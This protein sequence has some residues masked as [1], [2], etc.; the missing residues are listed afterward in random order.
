MSNERQLR[1]T[2]LQ[3]CTCAYWESTGEAHGLALYCP[4]TGHVQCAECGATLQ[5]QQPPQGNMVCSN[6]LR[7]I[8]KDM[9]PD[10]LWTLE[11]SLRQEGQQ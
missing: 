6:R 11:D 5:L 10:L 7:P 3:P 2:L 8:P 1:S 9:T 4:K